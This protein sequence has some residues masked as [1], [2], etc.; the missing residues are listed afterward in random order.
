MTV[1]FYVPLR[2]LKGLFRTYSSFT[3]MPFSSYSTEGASCSRQTA[4]EGTE[5]EV[6]LA[7]IIILTPWQDLF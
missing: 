7:S 4:V 2:N 6:E 1:I 5:V 3:Q